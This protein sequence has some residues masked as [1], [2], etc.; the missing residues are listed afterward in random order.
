MLNSSKPLSIYNASAGSGKTFRL[1]VEYIKLVI[2]N[3]QRFRNILAVTFTNKATAEMKTRILSQLYG[4]AHNDSESE[5]YIERIKEETGLSEAV[6]RNNA[7]IAL[8]L[9]IHNYSWFHIE[10]IDS[11]FQLVLKNLARELD[12][13]PGLRIELADK[14][15]VAE[16]AEKLIDELNESNDITSQLIS[17]AKENID[18]DNGWDVVKMLKSFSKN[19]LSDD[20]RRHADEIDKIFSQSGFISKYLDIL[21]AFIKKKETEI[22]S[23]G[24]KFFEIIN[25]KGITLDCGIQS[26]FINYFSSWKELTLKNEPLKVT[27]QR[28]LTDEK[29]WYKKGTSEEVVNIIKNELQPLFVKVEEIKAKLL[30]DYRKAIAVRKN[31]NQLSLLSTISR[32]VRED[33]E[34]AG[35]FLLSDTQT[36]LMQLI[37]DDD[38]P[39]VYEKIGQ[40]FDCIMIDEFQD[41]STS[42]WSN[43]R[44]LLKDCI[45]REGSRNIIVGD[46]KQSIYRWRSGDWTLLRDLPKDKSFKEITEVIP[47]DTN[48]RSAGNIIDFNNALFP[49]LI[50][51]EKES[52]TESVAKKGASANVEAIDEAYS[53]VFQHSIKKNEGIGLVSMQFFKG[54]D[55][56]KQIIETLDE[57]ITSLKEIGVNDSQIAILLRKR[58]ETEFIIKQF[59]LLHPEWKFV[60]EEAFHLYASTAVNIIILAMRCLIEPNDVFLHASLAD[61]YRRKVLNDNDVS[62]VKED[63]YK[64]LPTG[65]NNRNHLLTLPLYDLAE[66][67]FSIFSLERLKE[68]SEYVFLFFDVLTT[69]IGC[70]LGD[71]HSFLEEWDNSLKNKTINATSVDGIRLLTI[72]K[73]KG[74]EFD[75]VFIPFCNWKVTPNSNDIIWCK[76][77]ERPFNYLP[78]IPVSVNRDAFIGEYSEEYLQTSIDNLNLLYVAFTRPK[79]NLFIYGTLDNKTDRSKALEDSMKELSNSL[80]GSVLEPFGE[81]L[82]EGFSFSYG[83]LIVS[84]EENLKKNKEVS[85]ARLNVFNPIEIPLF[86]NLT[87]NSKG[88]INIFQSNESRLFARLIKN[89]YTTQVN[90]YSE[91][92]ADFNNTVITEGSYK[93]TLLSYKLLR[94][95]LINASTIDTTKLHNEIEKSKNNSS[96]LLN[97]HL[98]MLERMLQNKKIHKWY[99]GQYKKLANCSI[100]LPSRKNIFDTVSDQIDIDRLML[101]NE[102]YIAVNFL[103]EKPTS[104]DR[105]RLT[106]I[107]E[108]LHSTGC[109]PIKAFIVN[110]PSVVDGTINCSEG[111]EEIIIN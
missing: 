76:P 69:Y 84:R 109:S 102:G 59:S 65:F 85:P 99:S 62:L 42:Q 13:T 57:G 67:L 35:R 16:S 91:N 46:I 93:T 27:L 88:I 55:G 79:S 21:S 20:Y 8:K 31:I 19:L 106:K 5:S 26:V 28:G 89:A 96:L 83:E 50:E 2:A 40:Q 44:V 95:I 103:F 66:E 78:I 72:H 64:Y 94:Q 3:P 37:S 107:L 60:S 54:E 97:A 22:K 110:I 61:I 98:V 6:I 52:I 4:L 108:L 7:E 104:E 41:T 25:S 18:S 73:S 30:S 24:E 23:I 38:A 11:F 53:N 9:I 17:F 56:E 14:E 12:L 36:F 111:I 75:N 68:E 15:I 80:S 29:A 92:T 101:N 45:S 82:H 51:K 74:L 90:N 33:N 70:S 63:S 81:T 47:M 71:I 49:I 86:S 105:K 100:L 77:N 39:F 32:R 1:A 43:F 58:D 10:T 48:Y 87:N 34:E